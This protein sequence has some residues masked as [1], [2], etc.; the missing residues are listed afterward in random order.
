[1]CSC[2][3]VSALQITSGN[4]CR[5]MDWGCSLENS[6]NSWR[7]TV[8]VKL[9]SHSGQGRTQ[10]R[11]HSQTSFKLCLRAWCELFLSVLFSAECDVSD[12]PNA[13]I[14]SKTYNNVTGQVDLN[15][16]C[17]SGY[18]GNRCQFEDSNCDPTCEV[19]EYLFGPKGNSFCFC[20]EICFEK[21]ASELV[22]FSGTLLIKYFQ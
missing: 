13:D 15:C 4:E 1:M 20:G 6:K 11:I 12:C 10:H 14:C 21:K 22:G 16:T 19:G 18:H 2:L 17:R 3:R 8:F 5:L 7:E 9:N